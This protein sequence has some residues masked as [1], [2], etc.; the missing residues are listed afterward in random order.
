MQFYDRDFI[1]NKFKKNHIITNVVIINARKCNRSCD[2]CFIKDMNW[3]HIQFDDKEIIKTLSFLDNFIL[4][5]TGGEP[6]ID[7]EAM[8]VFEL[9]CKYNPQKIVINSNMDYY[10]ESFLLSLNKDI[11]V[12]TNSRKHIVFPKTK[13]DVWN[14]IFIDEINLKEFKYGSDYQYIFTVKFP[15]HFNKDIDISID[16]NLLKLTISKLKASGSKVRIFLNNTLDEYKEI[17]NEFISTNSRGIYNRIEF[18]KNWKDIPETDVITEECISCKNIAL[19][20]R[21]LYKEDIFDKSL[22]KNCDDLR[23]LIDLSIVENST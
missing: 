5:F 16:F 15:S 7:K 10:D 19:C 9:A 21:T 12:N 22:H 17:F 8:R 4:V 1:I 2:F 23:K 13:I 3:E 14:K 20:P 18:P 6:F 11:T